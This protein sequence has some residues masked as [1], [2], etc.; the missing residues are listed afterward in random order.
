MRRAH[1]PTIIQTEPIESGA[2]ALGIILGYY[3][4]FVPLEQLRI[5]CDIN[6]DGSLSYNILHAARQYGLEAEEKVVSDKELTTIP[7]PFMLN[8][9]HNHYLVV[10]GFQKDFIYVNDPAMGPRKI[11]YDELKT[12]FTG[13]TLSFKP[14][15]TFTKGGKP[16]PLLKLILKKFEGCAKPLSYLF[17]AGLFLVV[18]GIALPTFTQFFV[19]TI[20]LERIS[21]TALILI[22]ALSAT[23]VATALLTF[24]QSY[25][26]E[27]L[28]CKISIRLSCQFLW[29][30]L[31]LPIE[32]Y[33]Q[34]QGGEI[35][36][37]LNIADRVV[38]T[39]TAEFARAFI[40]FLLIF[41]Y[42]TL[43]F[44]YDVLIGWIA[45]A[46]ALTNLLVLLL[47]NRA[48]T[49][50]SIRLQQDMGKR[51]GILIGGLQN[52]ESIKAAAAEDD[53]FS[54]WAGY[55]AKSMNSLQDIGK[56][57]VY[58]TIIPS[59]TQFFT[60]AVVLTIGGLRVIDGNMTLGM[61]LALLMLVQ[62]FLTPIV[63][64]LYLGQRVQNV[65]GEL[66]RIEDVLSNPID[67]Q[68]E[69]K[70]I[71]EGSKLNGEIQLKN[72]TFGYSKL[73]APLIENFSLHIAPGK[74]VGLVGPSGCGKSTI[75]RLIT[76]LFH[77]WSGEILFDNK[78]LNTIHRHALNRSLA[79]VDQKVVLFEGTVRDN[80][81]LWD[82][83]L[84]DEDLIRGA[85]DASIHSKI[86]KREHGYESQVQEGGKN[87]SGGEQQCLE[88]A[89]TLALNPS[90]LILD[91]ATSSLDSTTEA[92]ILKK[93]RQRG[94]SSL[95]VAHRLSTIRDCH[96]IIVLEKG[97]VVDRGDHETLM[98][99]CPLYQELISF[100]GL[101]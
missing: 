24:L 62:I 88:I 79:A 26:V 37:R 9:Q 60:A 99:R 98:Q 96:E 7:T 45:V 20:L 11:T 49:D 52:M 84:P 12:N 21:S 57:D 78:P 1:T 48:R 2:V 10:E 101:Q 63:R 44:F 68:F 35:A 71:E 91:E 53:F 74:S 89:R 76:G 92:H 8:W 86:I 41:T 3:G 80:L 25:I 95:I 18:P 39:L 64:F 36:Y 90:C 65:K 54:R 32:F 69:M 47:I 56:F 27:R 31:R 72:V 87:F 23:V 17:I 77:P 67:P 43:I 46:A 40:S 94:C 5:A 58:L 22:L 66:Y 100:E 6:R 15:A 59:F 83:T 28:N 38:A 51:V 73:A 42:G 13:K 97:K 29:H 19:D 82:E 61:L 85:M 70:E 14:T 55:F 30:I 34:R 93:I 50:A 4:K 16:V 75:V 33:A 81:T